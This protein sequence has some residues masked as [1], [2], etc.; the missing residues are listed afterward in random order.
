MNEHSFLCRYMF[1]NAAWRQELPKRQ[2]QVRE[3]G[4]Y[5]ILNYMQ[6]ADFSD[7][8]VQEARGIIIDT[9]RME[10]VCWPFRKFGNH[11]ESYADPIDWST[12]RVQEKIDGSLVKL[13]YNE[14][15]GA[16]QWSSNGMIRAEEAGLL[17]GSGSFM[18]LIRRAEGFGDIHLE[19][20]RHDRTYMFELVAPEQRIVVRYLYPKLFHIGTR[21]NLTGEEFREDIG[22]PRPKEFPLHSLEECIEAAKA[23]NREGEE[24][25]QEGYVV[26]DGDFHRVKVKSPEYVFAHH[27]ATLR[28]YTKKRLMPIVMGGSA[29]VEEFLRQ[30][31]DAEMYVRYYQWQWA[32]LLRDAKVAVAK[33]RA[34]CEEL[35]RD[36][37]AVARALQGEPLKALCFLA[38]EDGRP[39]EEL[40]FSMPR[41]AIIR[42]IPDYP[43]AE[44][45]AG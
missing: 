9:E 26:V 20:L 42:R 33:A 25:R 37:R 3:S 17:D 30:A 1:S 43:R 24:V 39:A 29:Q 22:I 11:L 41:S 28:V 27:V 32:V 15:Q 19:S 35:G 21:S 5:A 36:R 34:M 44:V 18:D 7:P 4:P 6:E 45:L 38:L 31:P 14:R 12:A 10:V 13:W 40:I 16:W 23:L 2:I 8:L